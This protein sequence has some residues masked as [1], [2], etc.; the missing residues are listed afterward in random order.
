MDIRDNRITGFPK[1][2]R[3]L[4]ANAHKDDNLMAVAFWQGAII[5][6]QTYVKR[7]DIVFFLVGFILGMTSV[8]LTLSQTVLH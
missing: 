2:W 8:L 5:T 1:A 7:T 3:R 6:Q 4:K